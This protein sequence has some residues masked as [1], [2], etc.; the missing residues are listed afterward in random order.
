MY[1]YLYL[2]QNDPNA[3][4]PKPPRPYPG[5]PTGD[6]P[7]SLPRKSMRQKPTDQRSSAS[8]NSSGEMEPIGEMVS[9]KLSQNSVAKR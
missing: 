2:F 7:P 5:A 9:Y 1:S 3:P 8:S 6:E 4:P